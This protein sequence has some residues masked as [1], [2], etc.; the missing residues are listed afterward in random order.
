[1]FVPHQLSLL[2]PA[3]DNHVDL[4]SYATIMSESVTG[5]GEL[6]ITGPEMFQLLSMYIQ[7]CR[8]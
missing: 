8:F 7:S 5:S 4:A 3:D 6:Q 1:M 2:W